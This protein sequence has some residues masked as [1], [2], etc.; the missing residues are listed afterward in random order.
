MLASACCTA[1]HKSSAHTFAT[2]HTH[3]HPCVPRRPEP[4]VLL[5]RRPLGTD[6]VTGGIDQSLRRAEIEKYR[7]DIAEK[8][9]AQ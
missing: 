5:F 8:L 6:P 1:A 7:N 9:E 4:H 2:S 3:T